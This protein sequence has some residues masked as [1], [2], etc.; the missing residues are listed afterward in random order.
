MTHFDVEPAASAYATPVSYISVEKL[1]CYR[2]ALEF[3]VLVARLTIKGHRELRDQLSRASLSVIVNLSEGVGRS[4]GIDKARFYSIAR[5]SAMEC[6][7]IVDVVRSL[8]LAPTAICRDARNKLI[9]IVQMM[10]KLE[11]SARRL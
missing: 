2:V 4:S 10:T 9:R 3:Q 11:A 6:S 7:A 5:G 1:D 8:G